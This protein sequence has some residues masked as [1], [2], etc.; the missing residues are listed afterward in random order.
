MLRVTLVPWW[1]SYGLRCRVVDLC[2]LG[3]RF[4]AVDVDAGTDEIVRF[5]ADPP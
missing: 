1:D 2:Y 5:V 3:N 4:F